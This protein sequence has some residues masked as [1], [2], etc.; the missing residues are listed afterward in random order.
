MQAQRSL[1]G[2]IESHAAKERIRLPAFNATALRIQKE[3]AKED[4]DSR[5]IERLIVS[6][7]SLTGEV[8][9]VSNSSFYKGLAQVTTIRDALIRLGTKEVSNIVTLVAL[10]HNFASKIPLIN[11]IMKKLWRHSVGCGIGANW[12]AK[13]TRLQKI[14]HESF[15][16][17]L[18][19]DVGKLYILKV[20]DGMVASKE[21]DGPPSDTVINEVMESLHT[22]QGYSLMQRWNLPENYCLVARDHH[23]TEIDAHNLLLIL[24]RLAN[25]MCHKMGIGLKD[26]PSIVLHA[27]PEANQLQL[28]EVDMA[29]LEVRLEDSHVFAG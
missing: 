26:D 2:I 4:P 14:A 23:L 7:Q 29:R 19:H 21:I 24:V 1:V 5:L 25:Q 10:R 20:I 12:I 16:A 8:L 6:D 3:V 27:T 18:L 15:I 28:S 22:D 13:E 11:Q 17:G 9:R